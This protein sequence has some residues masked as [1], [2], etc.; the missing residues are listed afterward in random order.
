MVLYFK[1]SLNLIEFLFTFGLYDN[2]ANLTHCQN[3]LTIVAASTIRK[4]PANN[5]DVYPTVY[6]VG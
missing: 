3:N 2:V 1:N 6:R 4:G 5:P